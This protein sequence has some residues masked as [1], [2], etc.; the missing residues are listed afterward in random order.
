MLY[1]TTEVG[2]PELRI[3]IPNYDNDYNQQKKRSANE[4]DFKRIMNN[5]EGDNR[6]HNQYKKHQLKIKSVSVYSVCFD[7]CG[8][9]SVSDE[10]VF[11][12]FEQK[13][14]KCESSENP[15]YSSDEFS[16]DAAAAEVRI[17]NVEGFKLNSND[18]PISSCKSFDGHFSKIKNP[19]AAFGC[20]NK[21]N[22]N[23]NLI[24][25]VQ[26]RLFKTVQTL[27][28]FIESEGIPFYGRLTPESNPNYNSNEFHFKVSSF[29]SM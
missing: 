15:N 28:P 20:Y 12:P 17:S 10:F 5:N 1:G 2:Q 11:K 24:H 25:P 21:V 4:E 19:P 13:I 9:A 3:L 6:K 7:S 8:E 18:P 23:Q 22:N 14:N 29:L 16:M 27:N 26:F